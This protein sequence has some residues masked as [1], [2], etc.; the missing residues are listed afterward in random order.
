MTTIKNNEDKGDLRST[1]RVQI[2]RRGI[3]TVQQ[4][5]GDARIGG[6]PGQRLQ[7][8]EGAN[9]RGA[10]TETGVGDGCVTT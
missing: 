4:V 3:H 6:I 10:R 5:G 2:V 8:G 7:L 9:T 1:H